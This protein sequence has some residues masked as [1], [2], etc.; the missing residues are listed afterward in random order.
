MRLKRAD[1]E[2]STNTEETF[3][4]LIDKCD[5]IDALMLRAKIRL[6]LSRTTE[7]ASEK[8]QQMLDDAFAICGEGNIDAAKNMLEEAL[9]LAEQGATE[10][11]GA[12][13][14]ID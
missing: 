13:A 4:A 9:K 5:N 10:R 12:D 2:A 8:A 14:S 3:Q 1:N 11:L 6:Q 7:V